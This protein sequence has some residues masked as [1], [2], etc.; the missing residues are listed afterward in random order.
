MSIC[1]RWLLITGLILHVPHVL[2]STY[3]FA[4][5]SER[6]GTAAKSGRESLVEYVH[7]V[8]R[9]WKGD[10]VVDE[11]GKTFTLGQHLGSGGTNRIFSIGD[12]KIIRIPKAH[13][14]YW[15]KDYLDG[16]DVLRSAGVPIPFVNRES[17]PGQFVIVKEEQFQ[18]NLEEY[19]E[20]KVALTSAQ[21]GKVERDL[22]RFAATT[23]GFVKIGDFAADQIHY[24][25]KE[26]WILVDWTNSFVNYTWEHSLYS[27][28]FDVPRDGST[29]TL[30]Q[31]LP[32][33]LMSRIRFAIARARVLKSLTNTPQCAALL[34]QG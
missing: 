31:E 16:Y 24:V 30:S 25:E 5:F 18:F 28:A 29:T 32:K 19:L 12:G 21:R 9:L 6:N 34:G 17:G 23:S 7:T 8:A 13:C 22:V 15:S 4:D 33:P 20:D 26:G 3:H 10:V 2:A 14:D 1:L 27:S 11:D